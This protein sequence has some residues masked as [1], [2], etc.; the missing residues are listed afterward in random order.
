AER[1][2]GNAD[3]R[4]WRTSSKLIVHVMFLPCLRSP[5]IKISGYRTVR[6]KPLSFY[7]HYLKYPSDE[8]RELVEGFLQE[9]RKTPSGMLDQPLGKSLLKAQQAI[10]ADKM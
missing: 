2:S 3:S 6:D 7:E 5:V 8:N 4:A 9:A 10:E 1:R